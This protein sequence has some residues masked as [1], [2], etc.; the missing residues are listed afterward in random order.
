MLENEIEHTLEISN[1]ETQ[2]DE[3]AKKLLGNKKILA[4][5]LIYTVDE[6]RGMSPAEV[7]PLIEGDPVIGKVPVEP[8]LTNIHKMANIGEKSTT[9]GKT[10]ANEIAKIHRTKQ[11]L[12]ASKPSNRRNTQ[13]GKRIAKSGKRIVGLNTEN[14]EKNEGKIYFDVLFYVRM[15]DGLTQMIINVEA[16]KD[17][18]TGY[19]IINRAVFYVSRLI[20]S[21]KERDFVKMNF[22]D[23]KQ[24]YSIWICMNMS[25]NSLNHIH[26]TNDNLLG[27]TEWQGNLD[28]INIVMIGLSTELA[29]KEDEQEL[30]RLLGALFSQNL[31][32]AERIDVIENEYTGSME[33]SEREDVNIMCNLSQGIKEQALKEGRREGKIEGRREGKIEGRR[34]GRN[35]GRREGEMLILISQVCKKLA[36]G[37]SVE[38]IAENLE[39]ET[40]TI[41]RICKAAK[42]FAP[43]YDSEKIYNALQ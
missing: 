18:P 22:N 40:D 42:A 32:A 2:Y 13:F 17:E 39:A 16:Q 27:F 33:D 38:V 9:Q 3:T 19:D 12:N 36:K 24:V 20:S 4:C 10:H 37:K 7:I 6:F 1:A 8:G 25:N 21:Q 23:M 43:D 14:S 5:I 15:R 41:E 26:L 29:K 34:E 35:E 28:L 11:T 30:H 31:T